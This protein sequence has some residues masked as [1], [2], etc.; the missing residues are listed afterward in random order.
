[1]RFIVLLI[2]LASL[3]ALCSAFLLPKSQEDED[4]EGEN[5]NGLSRSQCMNVNLG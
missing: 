5:S 4:E 2:V 3:T 1:M